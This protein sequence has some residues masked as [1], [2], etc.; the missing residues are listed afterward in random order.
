MK[1]RILIITCLILVLILT[2]CGCKATSK[3]TNI[4]SS[5]MDD[6]TSHTSNILE[7]KSSNKESI[8]EKVS[9]HINSQEDNKNSTSKN[10]ISSSTSTDK[11]TISLTKNVTSKSV[12]GKK[13]D[14]KFINA[15]ANFAINLFKET[16]NN[17]KNQNTLISPL[18]AEIVLAM[19]FNGADGETK[20]EFKKLM[21]GINIEQLN[22]YL[23][24]YINKL[25]ASKIKLN[26]ANS[27][28]VK[29]GMPVNEEFLKIN[30]SYYD[31]EIFGTEF[32]ASTIKDINKWAS[33]NTD[34]MINKLLSD[35]DITKDT[36]MCLI[37]ALLFD[38]NW[39][40]QY[41]H[42]DA[43]QEFINAN[44]ETETV[45]TLKCSAYTY[46]N[47]E[48]ATGFKKEYVNN[49]FSFVALLPNENINI[50]DYINALTGEKLL[51][52]L[53]NPKD[54]S[55]NTQMPEFTYECNYDMIDVLS[56]LGI[57]SAFDSNKADFSKISNDLYISKSIHKTK[58]SVNEAGTKAAAV[59]TTFM[60]KVGMHSQEYEVIINRPFIYMIIDNKTN[61]P[62]FIG[63]VMNV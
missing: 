36:V 56:P 39:E 11:Q 34:D 43:T 18:S 15:Q 9:S 21:G 48:K 10:P 55:T 4:T 7:N 19:A 35:D 54:V 6:I 28:W 23:Y 38:A 57:V 12:S 31:S 51:K 58:I 17:N 32:N 26:I 2:I 47:D 42:S 30:K 16:I 8:I 60:T 41:S 3:I 22:E 20:K 1:K 40:S 37:N 44:G 52:T 62:I 45:Q 53:N 13:S 14:D 49:N 27:I 46:Y 24:S 5:K 63:A 29:N 61:L 59:S 25:D 50:Y 33:D